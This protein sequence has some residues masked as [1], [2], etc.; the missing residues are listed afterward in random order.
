MIYSPKIIINI[1]KHPFNHFYTNFNSIIIIVLGVNLK[2]RYWK[3][4]VEKV[5]PLGK[6]VTPKNTL[7]PPPL[8]QIKQSK[9]F[10]ISILTA[11]L[12]ID[13]LTHTFPTLLLV[14]TIAF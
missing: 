13:I 14:N 11:L 8:S 3:K 7:S 5:S 12:V 6:S 1:N 4:I 9:S 2:P 10:V